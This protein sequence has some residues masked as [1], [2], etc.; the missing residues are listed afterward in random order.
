MHSQK[1]ITYVWLQ[2][3][4][5]LLWCGLIYSLSA[6]STL[7]E[8]PFMIPYQDKIAHAGIYAWLAFF[9]C[10]SFRHILKKPLLIVLAAWLFCAAYG[11]SDEWHQSFVAERMPD[12]WDW[13]AD[14]S[15]AALMCAFLYF[16][17][18]TWIHREAT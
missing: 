6:Q 5:V 7:P 2:H 11:L 13:C 10:F 14:V 9:A 8:T 17:F 1:K 15:G 12:V 3:A 4:L 16:F 18:P